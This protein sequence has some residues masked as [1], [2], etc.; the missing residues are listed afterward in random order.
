MVKRQVLFVLLSLFLLVPCV[1]A[2]IVPRDFLIEVSKGNVP[3]HS[4]VAIAGI[5]ENVGTTEYVIWTEDGEFLFP[6]SALLMNVSS[7]SVVDNPGGIGMFNVT[8]IG[9]D[10]NYVVISETITLDGQTPVP[11]T[12]AYFR[13]NRLRGGAAG[14][15]EF[16]VGNIYIGTGSPTDGVP[17]VTYNVIDAE[18][19]DSTAATYTVP[20]GRSAL[21]VQLVFGTD[22]SKIIEYSLR[23]RCLDCGDNAW[24]VDYHSHFKEEH[25]DYVLPLPFPYPEHTDIKFQARNSVGSAFAETQVFLLEI[26]DAVLNNASLAWADSGV[27]DSVPVTLDTSTG[28]ITVSDP[29]NQTLLYVGLF[30]VIAL[31]LAA[32]ASGRKW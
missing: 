24:A 21:L 15:S 2:D 18:Q 6:A 23:S 30:I 4:L 10:A 28:A 13:V 31:G 16:N 19:G 5:D 17:V 14:S 8:V 20:D 3:G 27:V 26:T 22:S 12:L 11:T 25:Q 7:G 1:G 32:V 9:L 29:E